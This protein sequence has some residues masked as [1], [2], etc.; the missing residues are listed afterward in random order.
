MSTNPSTY[1]V[2][3]VYSAHGQALLVIV[4]VVYIGAWLAATRFRFLADADLVDERV[5]ASA[6]PS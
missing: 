3:A 4:A 1:L 6:A 2:K 5:L